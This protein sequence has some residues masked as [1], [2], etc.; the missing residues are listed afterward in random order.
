MSAF[1]R[2]AYLRRTAWSSSGR[3]AAP[4]RSA[5][6]TTWC[7]LAMFQVATRIVSWA[8]AGGVSA[9]PIE[10]ATT[11]AVSNLA[12]RMGMVHLRLALAW[13]FSGG[14]SLAGTDSLSEYAGAQF[15]HAG[16][17]GHVEQP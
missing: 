4:G 6:P 17:D 11:P 15:R 8:A 7:R 5:S 2:R 14:A 3:A 9:Q 16:G 10:S 13:E 12:D 1:M